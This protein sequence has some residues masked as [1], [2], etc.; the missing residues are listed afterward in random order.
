MQTNQT[1][2]ETQNHRHPHTTSRSQEMHSATSPV[3][4]TSS[5]SQEMN[6]TT[7]N[8]LT[9]FAAMLT[10]GLRRRR[11]VS[12]VAL[13]LLTA[14]VGFTATGQTAHAVSSA[15][16]AARGRALGDPTRS[17]CDSHPAPLDPSA[18]D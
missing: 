10:L 5:R 8:L 14:L 1:S 6:A 7:R 18:P 4:V 2:H 16:I 15:T 9:A 17:L 13:A 3:T 12:V 11:Q